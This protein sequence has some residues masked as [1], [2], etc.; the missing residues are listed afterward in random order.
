MTAAPILTTAVEPTEAA[1]KDVHDAPQDSGEARRA[2]ARE[3]ALA[4]ISGPPDAGAQGDDAKGDD[5]EPADGQPAKEPDDA[6]ARVAAAA[7]RA[8]ER[9]EARRGEASR[10][11]ELEAREARVREL[12]ARA[13]EMDQRI[14]AFQADPIDTMIKLGGDPRKLLERAQLA[15]LDPEKFAG[16]SAVEQTRAVADAAQRRVEE[17]EAKLAETHARNVQAEAESRFIRHAHEQAEHVPILASLPRDEQVYYMREMARA[18]VDRGMEISIDS[19]AAQVENHLQS[20]AERLSA[21]R[22][23]RAEPEK[24]T[25]TQKGKTLTNAQA[26]QHVTSKARTA[27]ERREAAIAALP[28]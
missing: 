8:R 4:S 22:K 27:H 14:R 19:V 3:A 9:R 23:K 1:T 11:Q 10:A 16:M 5:R 28:E 6:S 24:Q 18:M 20:E 25:T 17:L 26:A 7:K 2:S 12:E 21:P 13:A 15:V